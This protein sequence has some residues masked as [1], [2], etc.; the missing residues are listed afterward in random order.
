MPG[1]ADLQTRFID[2][3]SGKDGQI[4][5]SVAEQ[6]NINAATRLDIY[7]NAYQIRLTQVLETD[8]E[9]LGLYLG[10][11]LFEV[12]AKGYIESYPSG[13]TSLRHFGEHLPD[14]LEVAEPFNAHPILGEL[15]CFERRLL[16]VFDAADSTR[17]PLS[18][19]QAMPA[20]DWPGMTLRFH[21]STQ[22]FTANWNSIE[23]WKALKAGQEP[24]A[25]QLQEHA[26]WLLWRGDELLSEFRPVD[27][28][29]YRLLSLAIEGNSFAALCESLLSHHDEDR[30]GAI[31]LH[32]VSRWFE[33]GVITEINREG[34]S[35]HI[36]Y[37]CKQGTNI[38]TS[39]R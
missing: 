17:T 20:S 39:P 9:M 27:E 4:T 29:E 2:F 34:M 28:D 11:D 25:A 33:Q 15:A 23:S 38:I 19:L 12:M 26:V 30:I 13:Y 5:R 3:L 31:I 18:V 22:L 32:Y 21:P 6:G 16:D 14:Y 8:H 37:Q 7:R 1:L 36:K 24:P 10:D 35:A